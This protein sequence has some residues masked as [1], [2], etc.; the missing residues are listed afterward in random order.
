MNSTT[1]FDRI[2]T[3]LSYQQ[4]VFGPVAVDVN[5]PGLTASNAEAETGP[6]QSLDGIQSLEELKDFCAQTDALNTDLAGATLVFGVGNPKAT[7]ML[8]GEAPGETED[9]LGEPFVGDAGQLLN[10]MLAAIQIQRNEIYIANVGKRRPKDN[11]K[12]T[13]DECLRWYPFLKRQIELVNPS[14]ILALGGVAANTLLHRNDSV[15]SMRGS[16]HFWEQTQTRIL[17]TYHPSALLRD[18]SYKRPAWEDLKMLRKYLDELDKG[19]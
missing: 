4:E 9:R 12:P 6:N 16:L 13:A 2:E 14:V 19:A 1:I 17:V 5:A 3:F 11:R 8:V 10:K 18:E 15:L 7:L